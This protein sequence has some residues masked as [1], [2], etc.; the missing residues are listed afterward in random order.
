[1]RALSRRDARLWLLAGAALLLVLALV[2]R[3][4]EG[5]R[6]RF[7]LIAAVDITGSMNVRDYARGTSA[8]SRLDHV[9]DTLREL[10]LQMPCQSR[11]GLAV[12]SERRTFLLFEPLEICANFS[13][14]MGTIEALDW[15]M[16]WR[17]DSGIAYGLNDAIALAADTETDLVFITDGQEA[18]PLPT[19]GPPRFIGEPGEVGGLI[20]GVGG[21]ELAPIPKYDDEGREIGFYEPGDVPHESRVGQPPE[22]ANTREGWHPRNAPWGA[23][24]LIGDEHMS[25]LREDY[26]RERA[27]VTGLAYTRLEGAQAFIDAVFAAATPRPAVT[28]V[29]YRWLPAGLALALLIAVYGI[30]PLVGRA[31][32]RDHVNEGRSYKYEASGIVGS[33]RRSLRLSRFGARPH[34]ATGGGLNRHRGGA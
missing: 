29:D 1:M 18:P 14:L 9:K 20:V 7:D 8:I 16:A 3:P 19:H 13:P 15:R 4:I 25:A 23:E 27:Q 22:D 28:A 10:V 11:L 6:D 12:F 33:V 26:L 21:R 5:E 31:R 30:L 32:A 17:G 34:A 2:L 24:L